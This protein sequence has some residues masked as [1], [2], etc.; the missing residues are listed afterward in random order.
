MAAQRPRVGDEALRFSHSGGRHLLGFGPDFFG[1]WD[2][3]RPGGPVAR[4]PR[5]DDGWRDAWL[6]FVALEPHPSEIGLPGGPP[7]VRTSVSRTPAPSRPVSAAWW[8]LPILFGTIGGV[9]AWALTRGRDP[10]VAK[11]MLLTGIALSLVLLFIYMVSGPSSWAAGGV[12]GSRS[13]IDPSAPAWAFPRGGSLMIL[14]LLLLV[15]ILFGLG[16]VAKW[17]FIVAAVLFVLWLVG[18]LVRP[19]G[20]RWYYW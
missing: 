20:G 16:F 18:W 13:G 8:L 6:H 3:E 10:R 7:P 4:F 19:G 11:N 17:L 14:L 12:N 5:T 2:R 15:A 1:V 9:V